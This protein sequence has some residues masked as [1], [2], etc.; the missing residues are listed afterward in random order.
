MTTLLEQ[1]AALALDKQT[2]LNRIADTAA[3]W[4]VDLENGIL[5]L[6]DNSFTSAGCGCGQTRTSKCAQTKPIA[7]ASCA[8]T[9]PH[10]LQRPTVAALLPSSDIQPTAPCSRK[11][12]LHSMRLNCTTSLPLSAA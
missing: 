2:T 3:A 5:T 12:A 10:I 1:Y 8:N 6:G 9:P 7:P 4:R 11:N